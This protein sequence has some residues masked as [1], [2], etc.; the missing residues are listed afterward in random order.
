VTN[1]AAWLVDAHVHLHD[2]FPLI[3][4]FA[5]AAGH[6]RRSSR[7][8]SLPD[9]SIG[10]LMLAENE[11]EARF[12]Q[13][14]RRGLGPLTGE[15]SVR[16][17]AEAVSLLI[18]R[19]GRPCFALIAGRQVVTANRLEVL[20]L[21]TPEPVSNG[22]PIEDALDHAAAQEALA[23]VPW[24]FGKWW[25]RR[26]ARLRRLLE[27]DSGGA[28]FFLGDNGGRPQHL[29]T[30]ALLRGAAA[31]GTWN[32]PG[33]DPLPIPGDGYRTGSYGFLVPGAADLERPFAQ[34]RE[35]IGQ[36]SAQ[37][38]LFGRRAGLRHF[39]RAQ[40]AVRLKAH[41]RVCGAERRPH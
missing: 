41:T 26:G 20:T 10:C 40:A 39:V 6:F 16:P 3:D 23:I 9:G 21:G 1:T 35:S 14:Q 34:I 18:C 31:Q 27:C 8:L 2:A 22:R 4:S 36:L 32:L 7:E 11:G 5:A 37:P 28:G 17:T 15:W 12:R 13:F 38:Q 29:P 24:G 33:S 19:A 30:P 25:G